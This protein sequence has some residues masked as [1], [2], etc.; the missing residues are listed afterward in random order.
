MT[1]PPQAAEHRNVDSDSWRRIGGRAAFLSA[2]LIAVATALFVIEDA[3]LL[4]AEVTFHRTS[5]SYDHDVADFYARLLNRQHHV[6]WDYALRDAAGPLAFFALATAFLALNNVLRWKDAHAQLAFMFVSTAALLHTASDLLFLGD[7]AYFRHGGWSAASDPGGVAA[8]GRNSVAISNATDWI[9]GGSYASL[10]IGLILFA[11]AATS[12][13]PANRLIR[14]VAA[15]EATFLLVLVVGRATE[16]QT[17]FEVS[18]LGAGA[19]L[20]P[21]FGTLFGRALLR[22]ARC[23]GH[24]L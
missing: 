8:I 9:E 3:D 18:A 19:V 6:L 16:N 13:L 5:A 2:A 24:G 21:A 15:V 4:S 1:A 17:L 11:R 22:P 20:A 7:V 10:A 23:G 12:V 14:F